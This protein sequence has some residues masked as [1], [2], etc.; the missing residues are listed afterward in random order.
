MK[1]YL[2]Q[3]FLRNNHSKYAKYVNEW[4]GNLTEDQLAYFKLE[5][6][7]LHQ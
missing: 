5:K 2:V 7:R 6:E 4:V 1:A 3:R